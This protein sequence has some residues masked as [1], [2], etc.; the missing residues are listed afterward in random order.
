MLAHLRPAVVM[1]ALFTALTGIAY[2]LAVTGVA[3]AVLPFQ[4]NGSLLV[5]DKTV[6]GSA[7]IGQ[8]FSG[9]RYFHGRPSAAGQNGYD[10]A[11][12][13][14]S[15]LGPTSQKLIERVGATVNE[16]KSGGATTIPADAAT[17]SA[18]GLDPHVSPDFAAIQID[19]VAK[20]RGL[21]AERV[22]QIVALHT[23]LPFLGLIG[24][25]RVNVLKLNLALDA[26]AAPGSR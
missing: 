13:S 4:A 7:L 12:S 9:E 15:N 3:Q 22:R 17:T 24:E 2:P 21:G 1:I 10:A 5:R 26:E 19:R 23:E 25:P 11:A 18:S 20:A 16:L 8:A 6:V 14:G